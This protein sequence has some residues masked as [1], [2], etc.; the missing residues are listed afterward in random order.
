MNKIIV[1][2]TQNFMGME[3]PVV[4]GGFGE[5]CKAMLAK[6]IAEIHNQPLKKINQLINENLDEFEFGIDIL[7]LRPV[8]TEYQSLENVLLK[9]KRDSRFT[10]KSFK[11]NK[12]INKKY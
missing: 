5:G 3:I 7:D 4:E 9:L 12:K 10:F 1:R 8:L 11:I 6:T 2:G